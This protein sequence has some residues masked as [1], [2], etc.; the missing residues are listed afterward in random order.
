[1]KKLFIFFFFISILS[2]Y[3]VAQRRYLDPLFMVQCIEDVI[4]G[5]NISINDTLPFREALLLDLYLPIGDSQAKR[6]L[7]LITHTGNFL[8]LFFSGFPVGSKKDSSV[9]ATAQYLAARGFVAAVYTFRQVWAF[10]SVDEYF[11]NGSFV[12]AVYRGIQDTRTCIRYFKRSAI[13][14]NNLFG[15]D[16]GKI[17]VW[18]MGTGGYLALGAASLND[19]SE[20]L[21]NN[22]T[23]P[24]TLIHYIDTSVIGNIYGTNLATESIPNH[25]EYSSN[26]QLAVSVGGAILDSSWLDGEEIEPLYTGVHCTSAYVTPYHNGYH[27]TPHP[28]W[29]NASVSGTRKA[30]ELANQLNKNDAFKV[31]T[32][33]DDQLKLLIE[34]Q[35][36]RKIT[37]IINN[38]KLNMGT[39]NFYGFDVPIIYQGRPYVQEFPWDWWSYDTLVEVV[40]RINQLDSSNF[41]A[42]YL[43]RNGL[44]TNP[45][46]SAEKGRRYLDTI[47]ALVIPR[48]CIALNLGCFS[49]GLKSEKYTKHELKVYPNPITDQMILKIDPAVKIELVQVFR[50][51]GRLVFSKILNQPGDVTVSNLCL[52]PG[53]Y[54]IRANS[55][56]KIF[57]SRIIIR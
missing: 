3:V 40:K 51:D 41:D 36:S 9:V 19:V 53:L 29:V 15:I 43:H 33:E 54:L 21:T 52:P 18:G 46:M 31:L 50:L 49:T 1:M 56:N 48:L 39:D 24:N 57:S 42:D 30:I 16:T 20:I 55:E 38:Q 34:N 2:S 37:L 23:D 4:Y 25:P 5:E 17:C 14:Q 8:P 27:R 12:R 45:D 13:D 10:A 6:P 26:F 11:R 44:G 22:F 35:K 7:V 32:V 28:N 47:N